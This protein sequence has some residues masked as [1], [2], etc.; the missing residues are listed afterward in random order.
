M[1]L[2]CSICSDDALLWL[3]ELSM[4]ISHAM[5]TLEFPPT[6]RY[7]DQDLVHRSGQVA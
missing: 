5:L 3:F 7:P 4:V 2:V 1:V 6:L